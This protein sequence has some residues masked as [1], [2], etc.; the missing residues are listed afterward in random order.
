MSNVISDKA[1]VTGKGARIQTPRGAFM[2]RGMAKS[3]AMP[4][5]PGCLCKESAK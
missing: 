1:D 4:L 2:C 5:S 3:L